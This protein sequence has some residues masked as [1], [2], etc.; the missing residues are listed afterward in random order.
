MDNRRM[1]IMRSKIGY[2]LV[3]FAALLV[4]ASNQ[5]SSAAPAAKAQQGTSVGTEGS[6]AGTRTA[7]GSQNERSHRSWTMGN[8]IESKKNAVSINTENG[9]MVTLQVGPGTDVVV[10]GKKTSPNDLKL[11]PGADVFAAFEGT[12]QHA[13]AAILE[14]DDTGRGIHG[15]QSRMGNSATRSPKSTG[16]TQ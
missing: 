9:R 14:V 11:K 2:V 4:A 15:A 7:A 1:T 16:S 6:H 5:S 10:N 12:G 8:V 3:P 13:R